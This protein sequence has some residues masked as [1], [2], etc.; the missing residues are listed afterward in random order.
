LTSWKEKRVIGNATLYLGDCREVLHGLRDGCQNGDVSVEQGRGAG[1]DLKTRISAIVTDPPYGVGKDYGQHDDT[2]IM[3]FEWLNLCKS[4]GCP[5]LV[6]PGY[7]NIFDYPRP[8]GVMIRFDRTA[9]SPCGVA[10]MNKWEPIFIYGKLPSRF[11]WDVIETMTQ[12]EKLSEAR[13]DHPCPKSIHLMRKLVDKLG[14]NILDPFMGSGTTGVACMNLGRKFI[15]IEICEKYYN[16]AVERI[17]NAQRQRPL[18]D[19]ADSMYLA[20]GAD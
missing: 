9:Q 16:I 12:V 10:W 19:H 1:N 3:S 13:I 18:F 7:V 2:E 17:T 6:T 15:G 11:A 4:F 5:V 8:D 14:D 20:K